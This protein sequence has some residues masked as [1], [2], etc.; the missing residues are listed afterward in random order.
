M[1]KSTHHKYHL[2]GY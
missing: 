1:Q 2:K